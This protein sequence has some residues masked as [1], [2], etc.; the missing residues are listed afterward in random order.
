MVFPHLPSCNWCRDIG[1]A[2]QWAD[3]PK[4]GIAIALLDDLNLN[5]QIK[6][7][8]RLHPRSGILM[9]IFALLTF[10][11]TLFSVGKRDL[12]YFPSFRLGQPLLPVCQEEFITSYLG[13]NR[14]EILPY[15]R[16]I[17]G[18]HFPTTLVGKRFAHQRFAD[19]RKSIRK[20]KLR[21]IPAPIKIKSTLPPPPRP[22]IPPPLNRGILWTWKFSCRK[23]TEILGVH[24]IGTVISGPKIAD[25]N[26][27]DTRIFLKNLF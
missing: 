7:N 14:F 27:T 15:I 12:P 13:W 25:K 20:K 8:F 1:R 16:R 24:K 2:Y 21:R 22:K 9:R 5:K 26:F 6:N 19:S 11:R 17:I 23:N 3:F 4:V 10:L 18:K